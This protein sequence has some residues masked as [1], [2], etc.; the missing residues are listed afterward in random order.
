ML[1]TLIISLLSFCLLDFFVL[2]FF[3][4]MYYKSTNNLSFSHFNTVEIY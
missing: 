3:L 4:Q 2:V 1:R